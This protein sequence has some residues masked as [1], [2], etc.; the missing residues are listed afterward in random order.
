MCRPQLSFEIFR[1]NFCFRILMS[2]IKSRKILFKFQ[3]L[4]Y[5]HIEINS[6]ADKVSK[7]KLSY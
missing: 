2:L 3:F 5:K 1:I 4:V 6:M 7:N